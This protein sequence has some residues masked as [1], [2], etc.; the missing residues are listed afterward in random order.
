M[1]DVRQLLNDILYVPDPLLHPEGG[2]R[3]E[4]DPQGL[5]LQDTSSILKTAQTQLYQPSQEIFISYAWSGDSEEMANEIEKALATTDITLIRDKRDLGFKGRIQAF[6]AQIG[7]GNAVIVVISDKYLK[8]ENCMF[9]LV[10]IAANGDFY[11][12]IF[13]IVLPDA[14]IYKPV[15]RIRYIQHWEQEIAE[16]DEAMKSVGSANLQGFRESIDLY[17][18]IRNTIAELVDIL[19]DMNTLTPDLHSD[20]GFSELID[21]IQNRLKQD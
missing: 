7:Q 17:T 15:Q 20:S 13:P 8:S 10:E 12:R 21:A 19:K 2:I 1:V 11:D 16:L 9:E 18:R 14:Q 6:M 3:A 5:P 4:S